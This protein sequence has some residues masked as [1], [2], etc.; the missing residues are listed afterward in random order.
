MKRTIIA[1]LLAL[2]LVGWA[3][4]LPQLNEGSSARVTIGPF[5]DTDK[6]Y[7]IPQAVDVS[8]DYPAAPGKTSG[9]HLWSGHFVAADLVL[10]DLVSPCAIPTVGCY[11]TAIIPYTALNV[12]TRTDELPE[13][14]TSLVLEQARTTDRDTVLRAVLRALSF[15]EQDRAAY[16]AACSTLGRDVEVQLPGGEVVSGRAE[17]VD[18]HGRLVVDGTPYAAGD[19]VHLR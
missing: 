2:P 11:A 12:T 7:V 18:D 14:A 1:A 9:V 13:G 15:T 3:Q 16:R 19:V 5:M 17:E 10:A 4:P 8:L 6:V